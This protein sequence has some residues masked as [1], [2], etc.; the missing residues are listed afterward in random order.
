MDQLSLSVVG[1]GLAQAA[2]DEAVATVEVP[3]WHSSTWWGLFAPDGVHFVEEVVDW[4]GC[5]PRRSTTFSFEARISSVKTLSRPSGMYWPS[6]LISR[7]AGIVV[8][9]H[10]GA[11]VFKQVVMHAEA[12][13][14]NASGDERGSG[15]ARFKVN[16][17]DPVERALATDLQMYRR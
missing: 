7:P 5:F 9:S 4:I 14:G 12:T 15:G 2:N 16:R 10:S 8:G 1:A 11:N 13:L 17:D 6:G 3:L